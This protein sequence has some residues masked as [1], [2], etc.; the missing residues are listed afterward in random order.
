MAAN[1][2]P[3]TP[4][5]GHGVTRGRGLPLQYGQNSAGLPILNV[6][7]TSVGI[8]I[9]A[10]QGQPEQAT[11]QLLSHGRLANTST[12]PTQVSVSLLSLSLSLSFSFHF[13]SPSL[14][15]LHFVYVSYRRVLL[16]LLRS[17]QFLL[18]R[19]MYVL[20]GEGGYICA[21]MHVHVLMYACVGGW[22]CV[23]VCVVHVWMGR[24][25][26]VGV[27]VCVCVCVRACACV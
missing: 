22:M 5:P 23:W 3:L 21:H 2:T 24:C 26:C 16:F 15:S 7:G 20:G 25:L 27:S 11:Q 19:R 10:A 8:C 1:P 17:H 14:L 9:L 4:I 18:A 13:S 6:A 12:S